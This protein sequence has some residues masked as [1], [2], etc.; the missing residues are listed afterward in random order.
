MNQEY[1]EG[2]EALGEHGMVF[3]KFLSLFRVRIKGEEL[4]IRFGHNCVDEE[5]L[6][7]DEL[8]QFKTYLQE[9]RDWI[10]GLGKQADPKELQRRMWWVVEKM[11][12]F[13]FFTSSDQRTVMIWLD[14]CLSRLAE[15]TSASM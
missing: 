13:G 12:E 10:R 11:I 15:C 8:Q 7:A 9:Q 1:V 5:D 3:Y 4:S 14:I 6:K 2:L